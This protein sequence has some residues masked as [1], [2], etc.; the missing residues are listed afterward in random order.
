MSTIFVSGFISLSVQSNFMLFE[1]NMATTE[2]KEKRI[3]SGL[4]E[5]GMDDLFDL[6]W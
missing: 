5:N 2:E 1:W 4:M 6:Y 3:W